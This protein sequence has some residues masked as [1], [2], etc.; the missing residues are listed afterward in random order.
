M[1][2]VGLTAA[3]GLMPIRRVWGRGKMGHNRRKRG[4]NVVHL[5]GR[6]SPAEPPGATT[7]AARHCSS[8]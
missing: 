2:A 7:A 4:V 1:A 6:Q 5:N 8:R 3:S